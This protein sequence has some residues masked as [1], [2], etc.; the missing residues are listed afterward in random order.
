MKIVNVCSEAYPYVKTGGLGDVTYSLSKQLAKDNEVAIFLP[1]YST[2]KNKL[3]DPKLVGNVDVH[4]SWRHE[5]CNVFYEKNNGIN[6]YFI[7]NRHYFERE[8]IYGFDDD[9]ER[10]ALFTQAVV[11]AMEAIKLVPDIIHIHD[12]QV[13]MLPALIKENKLEFYKNTKFVLTIHNSAFLGYLDKDALGN[14]YNLPTDIFYNGNVK[15]FD[16]VSTLRAAIHYCDK[17]VAVSP[18]N[19]NELLNNES[20]NGLDGPLR[21]REFDF[22]GILNGIDVDGFNPKTDKYIT[23]NYDSSSIKNKIENKKLLCKKLGLSNENAPTFGVV[24]RVT[25][26]KG[27]DLIFGSIALLVSRGANVVILGSGEQ[28]YEAMMNEL[29]SRFPTQVAV[30]IGYNDELAHLIYAGSDFFLMPSLFEPC[31]LGQMI[32]QRYGALPLVRRVGG[33]KDS[34]I[35]FDGTNLSSANGIAFDFYS[36]EAMHGTINYALDIFYEKKKEFNRLV[37]NALMTD[38]SWQKSAQE[39]EMLYKSIINI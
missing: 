20:S 19:R 12:W 4:L 9:G 37:I 1:L 34:V 6:F 27:M 28:R 31:G 29:H 15:L 16:R 2:I 36:L 7:E 21:M 38:H 14:L 30:Y 33:L 11:K 18:T 10:F 3:S 17:I 32:A 13:G 39:Y 23:S 24:T 25:W 8:G 22:T 35:G 26:Q 5:Q